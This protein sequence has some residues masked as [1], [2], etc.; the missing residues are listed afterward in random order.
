[1]ASLGCRGQCM[2][3]RQ[4]VKWI[5]DRLTPAPNVDMTML[6]TRACMHTHRH[7][8]IVS[9]SHTGGNMNGIVFIHL[10]V[11][12]QSEQMCQWSRRVFFGAL[13]FLTQEK[14]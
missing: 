5:S 6:C 10:A 4:K 12:K 7:A 1:M 9:L 14:N 11:W 8:H 3:M 2:Q 13:W